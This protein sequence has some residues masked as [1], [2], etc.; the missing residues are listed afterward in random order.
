M[1]AMTTH[2][3]SATLLLG[4]VVLAFSLTMLALAILRFDWLKRQMPFLCR[5]GGVSFS[6]PAS[7][8]GVGA[9]SIIGIVIGL[10]CVDSWFQLLT[11]FPW[12]AL[13]GWSIGIAFFVAMFDLATHRGGHV[14]HEGRKR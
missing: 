2:A 14:K 13:V 9:Q 3:T 10:S 8:Y 11:P 7:R 4:A 1:F 5:W 12:G 6:Y